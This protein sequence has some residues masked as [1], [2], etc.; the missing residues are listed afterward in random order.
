M[1]NITNLSSLIQAGLIFKCLK[2]GMTIIIFTMNGTINDYFVSTFFFATSA[3]GLVYLS[4]CGYNFPLTPKDK[5]SED[6]VYILRCQIEKDIISREQDMAFWL[7]FVVAAFF[8]C[9]SIF[10]IRMN[11]LVFGKGQEVTAMGTSAAIMILTNLI[12]WPSIL[13]G[14]R[15]QMPLREERTHLKRASEFLGQLN[16]ILNFC[17]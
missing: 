12:A 7:L 4:K 9:I 2:G 6:P 13:E 8:F 5:Q 14:I 17:S 16:E 15:A 10:S 3:C 11:V 1:A